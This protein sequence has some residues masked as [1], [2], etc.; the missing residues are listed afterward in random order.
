MEQDI[1]YEA[2]FQRLRQITGATTD[3]AL[4]RLL[5]IKPQSVVAARKRR[6]IPPGWIVTI[7]RHYGVT[8]DWLFFGIGP[9]SREDKP[10][11]TE[12]PRLYP[13]EDDTPA[14]LRRRFAEQEK[15]IHELEKALAEAREETLKA[16]RLAVEA[17]RTPVDAV[18][19]PPPPRYGHSAAIQGDGSAKRQ[20]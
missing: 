3:S 7:A 8:T 6:Q 5:D 12:P 14:D 11:A 10:E 2:V 15:R 19:V 16:Y 13:V 20:K 17:M 18:Q 1:S 9:V 4:A